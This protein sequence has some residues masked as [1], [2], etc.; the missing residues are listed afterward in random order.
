MKKLVLI[1]LVVLISFFDSATAQTPSF[2][3]SISINQD[4]NSSSEIYPFSGEQVYGIGIN[5]NV[6]F[7]SDTSIVRVI[8]RDSLSI[9]YLIYSTNTYLDSLNNFSFSEECEETCFFDGF[10]PTSI[11]IQILGATLNLDNVLFTDQPVANAPALQSQA[12]QAKVAVKIQKMNDFISNE[13]LIWVAGETSYTNMYFEQKKELYKSSLWN[14]AIEYYVSGVFG[15]QSIRNGANITVNYDFVDNFDWRNRHDANNPSSSYYD[16]SSDGSGWVTPAACQNGC[17]I[18]GVVDCSLNSWEC[19]GDWR[20]AGTCWAFG[21]TSHV[22]ALVNLYLNQHYDV[23][24]AEQDIVS[25]ALDEPHPEPGSTS[26]SYNHFIDYGVVDEGCFP[27]TA[28]GTPCGYKCNNPVEQISISNYSYK[29]HPP[30]NE[31]RTDIIHQGPMNATFMNCMWGPWS[32]AMQLVGWDV[33]EYGDENIL[34]VP[35]DPEVF[36][37]YVGCTYWIY[38]ENYGNRNDQNGFF[39]MIHENDDTPNIYI[40]PTNTSEFV[41]SNLNNFDEYDI[42][43]LDNDGD[44]YY[45]WGIGPKPD[46]CPPCPDEPDGNDNN[47]GLGPINNKGFCTIIDTYNSSFEKSMNNWKQ[48]EDDD[49]D[50]IKYFGATNNYPDSG[51]NGTPDGSTYYVYMNASKCYLNSGAYLESPPIDLTNACAIEMTFAYHKNTYTWGN[52]D[53]D[54]SKLAIDIS[55]DNGQTWEEDYWYVI[56]DQGNEWHY[57]TIQ[58]PSEVNN[59][60]FYAYVGWVNFYNDI[61]IDDITI[62]P[63]ENNS[64]VISSNEQWDC[65][66]EICQNIIIEPDATL[67]LN[68]G[69]VVRMN[70]NNKVIVKR[71]AKLYVNGGTLTSSGSNWKGIEVWGNS[72]FE[73]S[74]QDHGLVELSNGA[75]MENSTHGIYTN[76]PLPS[77]ASLWDPGYTGGIISA[78]DAHFI[79]NTVAATFYTYNHLSWSSFDGCTFSVNNNYFD[80]ELPVNMLKITGMNGI[81]IENCD[82]KNLTN[83]PQQMIGVSSH[84]SLVFV[85][86]ECTVQQAPCT[87]WNKGLFENLEYGIYATSSNTNYHIDIRNTIFTEN[88]KGVYISGMS[89]ARI[90]SNQFNISNYA[91]DEGYGLYLDHSTDYWVEDNNLYKC[92]GCT[93]PIGTGII[94]NQSGGNPNEIYRND[95]ISLENAI[96]VQG[97]NRNPRNPAEGLVL[98]CNTYTNTLYDEVIIYDN[99]Y[100]QAAGIAR[101]QGLDSQEIEDMAGNV[102]HYNTIPDDFDD[103]NNSGNNIDYYY[104]SNTNEIQVEPID[105]TDNT[106]QRISRN[107]NLTW[108]HADACPSCLGGSGGI[109]V[110]R[111]LMTTSQS[112]IDSTQTILDAMMD[113]GDTEALNNEVEF[114]IPPEA[115]EVYNELM[116]AS[117]NVSDQVVGTSIEKE[118]V[119]PNVMIRDV[120]VA[121]PHSAK[122][123]ALMDM[124][125]ERYEPMPDYM[126]AEILAGKSLTTLKQQ[127]E[128]DIAASKLKRMKSMNKQIRYYKEDLLDW[129]QVTDSMLALYQDINILENHYKTAWL[130]LIREEYEQGQVVLD[131]IPVT[132]DLTEKETIEWQKTDELYALLKDLYSSGKSVF[133]LSDEQYNTLNTL[134]L[135]NAGLPSVYAR[136]ILLTID[137]IYYQEPILL[138]DPL[139]SGRMVEEYR[140]IMDAEAP[141][142]L[143]VYPNPGKHYIVLEYSLEQ[144][145]GG[146]IEIKESYGQVIKILETGKQQDQ[147]LINTENWKS[148]MYIAS[149]IADENSMESVKFTIVK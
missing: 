136:N 116:N 87:D 128:G 108:N 20:T 41:S 104:S 37:D 94:V 86:A 100:S 148:G 68:P 54:D 80:S 9:D 18:N 58:I 117:P 96:I 137:S 66:H 115:N 107:T 35:P 32:H 123:Q 65:S 59:L 71:G 93:G 121:N 127:L 56:G 34:G 22:E 78:Y 112:E 6:S 138:P 126:K 63:A 144:R 89:G 21:P 122:S 36:D 24:L 69:S 83:T 139:K 77:D 106:V 51:P 130:H 60:R 140:E 47:A 118:E 114:S 52:D 50:W 57:Q 31:F 84:N 27:Y 42:L 91:L 33:I 145:T 30:Q 147:V 74:F 134:E 62:G 1:N 119:L 129:Q 10:R 99:A 92:I 14:P 3:D 146:V 111:S 49:C 67:T 103:L 29:Y 110:E 15:L 141:Q 76:K 102:F 85:K 17:W 7:N 124:L 81:E 26:W 133:E 40:V 44:G 90:T 8:L 43:C 25:C 39:Y 4:Y 125:D 95:F 23:D 75:V 45:N 72:N 82:F 70:E 142:F 113:G 120:M 2:N 12:K 105:Y 16:G 61:A 143:K 28:Q 149:F 135:C 53:T 101:D 131:N 79:N 98:K 11:E 97:E 73:Q 64:R 38:K 55:Y 48:V 46:H 88:Y 13:G 5:G 132:H 19:S 109:E